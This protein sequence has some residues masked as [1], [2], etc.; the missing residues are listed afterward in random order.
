MKETPALVRCCHFG[1]TLPFFETEHRNARTGQPAVLLREYGP[2]L[3][4]PAK[5]RDTQSRHIPATHPGN[6]LHVLWQTALLAT[7]QIQSSGHPGHEA[8]IPPCSQ[9]FIGLC[10]ILVNA[11]RHE[12]HVACGLPGSKFPRFAGRNL[13][14]GARSHLY[15]TLLRAQK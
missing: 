2:Q 11:V 8:P 4:N 3:G 14:A 9:S 13:V 6:A 10:T 15:R 1:G 5:H 12:A 7:Y